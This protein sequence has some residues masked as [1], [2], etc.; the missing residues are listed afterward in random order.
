VRTLKAAFQ[1]AEDWGKINSNPFKK[2]K[3]IKV[4]LKNPR[5]IS[6]TE[7]DALCT[8][9]TGDWLLDIV[10]FAVLT[11]LRL[12]EILNLKW[13]NVDLSNRRITI[14]SSEGDQVKCGKCRV[15]PLNKDALEVLKGLKNHTA[16]VFADANDNRFNSNTVSKKFK[17][18][19]R[20]CSLPADIHFHTLRTTFASWGINNGIPA[21]AMKTLLGH[22]SVKTT[23]GYSAFDDN[24]LREAVEKVSI[25]SKPALD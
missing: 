2:V 12:G 10:K 21:Y 8:A 15:V 24:G 23:E 5:P 14:E 3:E 19:V 9:M 25:G 17:K 13:D 22:S 20:S 1:L 4:P 11:G 6:R 7:F 16:W 18:Y